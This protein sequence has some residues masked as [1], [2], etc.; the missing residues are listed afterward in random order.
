G[1]GR[2]GE[3]RIVHGKV[4][5]R[6]TAVDD[7]WHPPVRRTDDAGRDLR[8]LRLVELENLAADGDPEAVHAGP[9]VELDEIGEALLV[10]ATVHV[11][12]S[13][14]DR[15]D[16]MQHGKRHC[17]APAYQWVF[18]VVALGSIRLSL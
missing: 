17:L 12:R 7:D 15:H 1:A 5:A 13:D 11:E 2:L 4:R 9:D 18:L 8:P 6:R 3:P 14:E 10:D 16:A